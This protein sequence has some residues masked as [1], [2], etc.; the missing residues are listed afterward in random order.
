MIQIRLTDGVPRRK[1]VWVA[2][3]PIPKARGKQYNSLLECGHNT[4][5]YQWQRKKGWSFCFDCHYKKPVP[6]V[7]KV[8]LQQLPLSGD[9]LNAAERE[10]REIK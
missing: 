9:K 7:N 3:L 6:E 2:D 5:T 1:I 4:K 10:A 8:F